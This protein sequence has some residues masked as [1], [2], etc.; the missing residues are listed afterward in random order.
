MP[1]NRIMMALTMVC[2]TK[3]VAMVFMRISKGLRVVAVVAVP[4]YY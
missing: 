1:A 4:L 2:T 3:A